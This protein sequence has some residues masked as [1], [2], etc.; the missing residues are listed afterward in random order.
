MQ[1]KD[2]VAPDLSPLVFDTMLSKITVND[3]KAT[4][5]I[6]RL[7]VLSFG[8]SEL[9]FTRTVLTEGH[10]QVWERQKDHRRVLGP[11][12]WEEPPTDAKDKGE[13]GTSVSKKGI[14]DILTGL[15]VIMV[16]LSLAGLLGPV[17]DLLISAGEGILNIEATN[18]RA[19]LV[20]I[21]IVLALILIA[22]GW[23]LKVM[24]WAITLY[25]WFGAWI[26]DLIKPTYIPMGVYS[27]FKE[28]QEKTSDMTY[29]KVKQDV[30]T[31]KSILRKEYDL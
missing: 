10:L 19:W 16:V 23:L 11:I 17:A 27:P 15:I 2:R 25:Q 13:Q 18:R 26:E 8:L 3:P 6:Y 4:P 31:M 24:D 9:E 20:A 14:A 21:R 1:Y 12:F 30:S 22:V 5:D 7:G 28:Q 29:E